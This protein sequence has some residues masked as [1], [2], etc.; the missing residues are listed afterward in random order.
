VKANLHVLFDW[1]V[2]I[3]PLIMGALALLVIRLR[4]ERLP[5]VRHIWIWQWLWPLAACAVY[6]PIHVEPRFLGAF[7]AIFWVGVY[8]Y[9]LPNSPVGTRAAVLVTVIAMLLLPFAASRT[10]AMLASLRHPD[11]PADQIAAK[12]LRSL[13]L[14]PGDLLATVGVDFQ[15]FYARRSHLRTVAYVEVPEGPWSLPAAQFAR[16]KACLASAGIQALVARG[17]PS[18][19][20]PREWTE[21]DLAGAGKLQVVTLPASAHRP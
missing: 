10:R 4:K 19:P 21:I 11:P 3:W 16:V 9:L 18:L 14:K 2:G 7:L 5:G 6:L 12:A 8:G 17:R 1:A 13:G 20:N 15:P